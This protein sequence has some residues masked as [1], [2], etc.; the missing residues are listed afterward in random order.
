M[1]LENYFN[2]PKEKRIEVLKELKFQLLTLEEQDE[3]LQCLHSY[4]P[5]EIIDDLNFTEYLH[6]VIETISK[7]RFDLSCK[8]SE[9]KNHMVQFCPECGEIITSE[10]PYHNAAHNWS[11]DCK[12]GWSRNIII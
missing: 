5:F 10:E 4:Y 1:G 8:L 12:C 3:I 2:L 7:Q 6:Y 9:V 11:F